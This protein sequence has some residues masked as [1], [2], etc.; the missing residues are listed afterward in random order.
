[1]NVNHAF[2]LLLAA[3]V[4]AFAGLYYHSLQQEQRYHGEAIPYLVE[5]MDDVSHWEV[6][7][8]WP[9]LSE[10][11]REV[12]QPEQ[13]ANLLG[14][15]SG[16]GRFQEMDEPDFSHLAAA[17]SLFSADT[18]LGYSFTAYFDNGSA[19]ITATLLEEDGRFSI[20]NFNI[21]GAA[22]GSR[23]RPVNG[24]GAAT[25]P[26]RRFSSPRPACPA[27]ATTAPVRRRRQYARRR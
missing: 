16:L 7:R 5:L 18:R 9:H 22:P 23:R 20:Y 2:Y 19:K 8:F 27:R 15:Y 1:M 6:E 10:R 3:L 25:A 21:V 13:I 17:M 11:A 12:V 14:Q 4:L 24:R 26:H